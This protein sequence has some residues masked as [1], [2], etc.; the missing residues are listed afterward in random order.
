MSFIIYDTIYMPSVSVATDHEAKRGRAPFFD[1][2]V[3][4]DIVIFYF[5]ARGAS[6]SKNQQLYRTGKIIKS[7]ILAIHMHIYKY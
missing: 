3:F 7:A 5:S 1:C 4:W 6:C 2:F